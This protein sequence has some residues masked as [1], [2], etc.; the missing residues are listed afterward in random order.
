MSITTRRSYCWNSGLITSA[1]L[2]LRVALTMAKPFSGPR[3]DL[4]WLGALY[5]VLFLLVFAAIQKMV[6]GLRPAARLVVPAA[7]LVV[8]CGASYI[9]WFDSFYFDSAS[10][11]FLWCAVLLCVRLLLFEKVTTWDYLAALASVVVFETTKSQHTALALP[12]IACFWLPSGRAT[13]PRLPLRVA[14]T[15]AVVAAGVCDVRERSALVSDHQL[16]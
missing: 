9:P 1:V 10:Y 16:L 14:A 3:F 5:G 13:F 6:R 7:V 2:P 12:L 15:L 11:V 4:R 8:F